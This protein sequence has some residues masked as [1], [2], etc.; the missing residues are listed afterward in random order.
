MAVRTFQFN[1]PQGTAVRIVE[2]WHAPQDVMVHNHEHATSKNVYIGYDET[3]SATTGFDIDA[4]VNVPLTLPAGDEL[5]AFTDES[6]GAELHILA[7]NK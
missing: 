3:V 5:W 6:G 4:A 1:L 2:R 7:V